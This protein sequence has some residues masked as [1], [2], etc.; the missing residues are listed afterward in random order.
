MWILCINHQNMHGCLRRVDSNCFVE[1]YGMMF[2]AGAYT[3][4]DEKL[5]LYS[6]YSNKMG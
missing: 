2:I 6:D 5:E 4:Y 3:I 1:T